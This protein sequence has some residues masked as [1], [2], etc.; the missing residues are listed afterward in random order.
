MAD[1]NGRI[2]QENVTVPWRQVLHLQIADAELK[3]HTESFLDF[4][5]KSTFFYKTTDP[6][7]GKLLDQR[8]SGQEALRAIKTRMDLY[9]NGPEHI[10]ELRR[11]VMGATELGPGRKIEWVEDKL[12]IADHG[13]P[14]NKDD[15][16]SGMITQ[17]LDASRR[18]PIAIH[19]GRDY[20]K[21]AQYYDK[22]GKTHPITVDGAL[23]HELGH[24]A[25]R[26]ADEMV[27]TT[28]EAVVVGAMGGVPRETTSRPRYNFEKNSNGGYKVLPKGPQRGG[29]WYLH[30]G[31]K[32]NFATVNKA[33]I[34]AAMREIKTAETPRQEFTT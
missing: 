32:P 33:E 12:T 17:Y 13:L 5:E 15:L 30:P 4:F 34:Q 26:S 22:D 27:A 2:A 24:V 3:K 20:L 10:K 23:A 14:F 16:T 19:V 29:N 6:A 21:G 8:F 18:L 28:V 7:T 9:K 1:K 25:Y 31:A 11:K